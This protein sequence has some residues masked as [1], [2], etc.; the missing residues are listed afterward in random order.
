MIQAASVSAQP[1]CSPQLLRHKDPPSSGRSLAA[2][3]VKLH[4]KK[5]TAAVNQTLD[6]ALRFL[7]VRVG[8]SDI[9]VGSEGQAAIEFNTS[10]DTNRSTPRLSTEIYFKISSNFFCFFLLNL[11]LADTYLRAGYGPAP[12][13]LAE[14]SSPAAGGSPV[15]QRHGKTHDVSKRLRLRRCFSSCVLK[16][17]FMRTDKREEKK[18]REL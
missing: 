13:R 10:G 4:R 17:G 18:K 6:T 15:K 11:S 14:A 1:F 2:A 7:R 16:T 5:N 3:G 12:A 9:R 8:V